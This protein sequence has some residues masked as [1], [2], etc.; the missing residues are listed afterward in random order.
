MRKRWVGLGVA[1]L[2][3]LTAGAQAHVGK[4]HDAVPWC[5]TRDLGQ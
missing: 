3:T 1:A 2:V 4:T 5:T